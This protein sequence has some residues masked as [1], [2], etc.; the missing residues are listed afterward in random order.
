MQF[1]QGVGVYKTNGDKLGSV[2]RVVLNPETREI[3]HVIIRQGSFLSPEDRVAPLQYIDSATED[4]VVLRD[5]VQDLDHLPLFEQT[6]YVPFTPEA[7][8][9][10]TAYQSGYAQPM[11]WYPPLAAPRR[12]HPAVSGLG[13]NKEPYLVQQEINIPEGTTALKEGAKVVAADG[14]HI[15]EI[16]RVYADPDSDVATHFLISKGL[17]LKTNKLIPA[18]WAKTIAEDEVQLSVSSELIEQLPEY[19]D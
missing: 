15:G 2:E 13:T 17:I 19:E 4:R 1:Q 11:L 10:M 6:Y 16:E 12:G 3:T 14:K 8:D 18:E 7:G 5:H 9:E